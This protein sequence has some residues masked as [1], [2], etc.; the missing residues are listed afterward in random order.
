MSVE[1]ETIGEKELLITNTVKIEQNVIKRV[2]E[3]PSKEDSSIHEQ[4]TLIIDVQ[5]PITEEVLDEKIT[6]VEEPSISAPI[7][8]IMVLL[9]SKKATLDEQVLHGS[10]DL[11]KQAISNKPIRHPSTVQ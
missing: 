8:G 1:Q 9:E 10:G 6:T 5:E 11:G 2:P 3:L 7:Q 4:T